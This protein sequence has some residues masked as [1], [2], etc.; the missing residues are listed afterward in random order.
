M[1]ADSTL[2]LCRT[3]TVQMNPESLSFDVQELSNIHE[4]YAKMKTA[5]TASSEQAVS[6]IDL[7]RKNLVPELHG[8][9]MDFYKWQQSGVGRTFLE[10]MFEY[11][12][13]SFCTFCV[14][15]GFDEMPC[16]VRTPLM[17][18]VRTTVVKDRRHSRRSVQLS[19]CSCVIA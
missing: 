6:S 19:R 15:C 13:F 11:C 16:L 8:T 4:L 3:L 7:I 2:T 5:V 1:S 17:T 9:V 10:R 12:F 18:T 14:R